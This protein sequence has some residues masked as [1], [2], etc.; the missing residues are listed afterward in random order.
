MPYHHTQIDIIT[1]FTILDDAKRV[2]ACMRHQFVL[3]DKASLVC[4]MEEHMMLVLFLKMS[5]Y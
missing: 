2:I 3:S 4:D 5:V 1:T